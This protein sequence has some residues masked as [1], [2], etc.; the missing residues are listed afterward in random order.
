MPHRC[1]TAP[2]RGQGVPSK[3]CGAWSVLALVSAVL[4]SGGVVAL[5]ADAAPVGRGAAAQADQVFTQRGVAVDVTAGNAT[6]ARDR[7]IAQAESLALSR[8]YA[9]L[10]PAGDAHQPPAL[11]PAELD[12]LVA[13]FEVEGE[14]TSAVR[15]LGR[16]TVSFRPEA[17]RQ[18][19]ARTNTRYA[20]VVAKPALILPLDLS[21]AEPA[22]WTDGPWRQAWLALTTGAAAQGGWAT[23]PLEGLLPLVVAPAD[24]ADQADLTAK[25]ALSPDPAA[26]AR[27]ARRHNAGQVV[28][29]RLEGD[30]ARG[31]Q[32][33]LRSWSASGQPSAE[34][35]PVTLG[36]SAFIAAPALPDAGPGA[37]PSPPAP[38]L[39]AVATASAHL[40]EAWKRRVLV[41]RPGESELAVVVALPPSSPPLPSAATNQP[42]APVAAV[43]PAA[44]I[45]PPPPAVAPP[46]APAGPPAGLATLVEVRR[47]LS[48]VPLVGRADVVSLSPARAVLRLSYRGDLERLR[49]A[50]AQDDLTL[51]EAV[52]LPVSALAS[53]PASPAA[54]VDPVFYSLQLASGS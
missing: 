21:G 54:P 28:I 11:S 23:A 52:A 53:P 7:A 41:E 39:Q 17:V 14:R 24:P 38:L 19:M 34:A 42:P 18:L 51:G 32:I 48:L 46:V 1:N 29:A 26:L 50:L 6:Q 2:H 45:I 40:Q 36:Q 12:A 31:Y 25:A 9:K 37:P 3:G 35:E 33:T 27:I 15:Y 43:R 8:L 22:L 16:M 13:G 47:R 44:A 10:T 30:A 4:V 20:E 5:P 49:T